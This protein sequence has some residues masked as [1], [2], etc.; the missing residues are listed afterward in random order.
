ML[1][2]HDAETKDCELSELFAG[3]LVRIAYN[4]VSISDPDG[5]EQVLKSKM[6]KVRL[7]PPSEHS[8]QSSALMTRR[9]CDYQ[10]DWYKITSLPDSRF[11]NQM[12]ETNA[13]RHIEKQKNIAS[14]YTLSNIIKSEPYI[15][16]L[17]SLFRSLLDEL[18]AAKQPVKF[19]QWFNYLAFDIVG[20]VTFS[21]QF[22]FLVQGRDI[23]NAIANQGFLTLYLSVVGYF[24]WVHNL[25]LANPLIEYF[26]LQPAMHVFDTCVAAIDARSKNDKVRKDMIEQWMDTRK[27]HPESMD[28]KEIFAAAVAT[29]G[30]GADTISAVLQALFYYL[31]R[32]PKTFDLLREEIDNAQLSSVPSYEETQKLELLQACIKETYRFHTPVSL[33]LSR[34][35]PPGGV[36]VCGRHFEPGVLLSINPWAI[37]RLTS[38]F[39]ADADSFNPLRWLGNSDSVRQ[40]DRNMVAFGAGYNQ[41][42]GRNPAHL[43]VSK[44]AALMVRDYDIKQINPG[45]E[46][47]FMSH[48]AA[49]PHDWPCWVTPR[50]RS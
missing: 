42:P 11:I 30:A 13:R 12:S 19:E 5:I 16:N 22:G 20:E 50:K 34:I 38:I 4:E 6:D 40:M 10:G 24:Q 21:R 39:G 9:V 37:H 35:S 31:L 3:K 47:K 23:G 26:N 43:E 18:A 33:N 48:F 41:C 15:D 8:K 46:W 29:I 49:I 45:Q 25:L 44:A 14:G 1:H 7:Y 17:L 28:R 32:S 2:L 27:K 36:T